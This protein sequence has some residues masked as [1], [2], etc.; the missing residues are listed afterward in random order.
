[1]DLAQEAGLDRSWPHPPRIAL[2]LTMIEY[3][4]NS[5]ISL[6]FSRFDIER[7]R[8]AATIA[9]IILGRGHGFVTRDFCR[10]DGASFK[11]N[12]QPYEIVPKIDAVTLLG[13]NTC[14]MVA[15]GANFVWKRKQFCI[16]FRLF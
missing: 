13:V 1:M 6:T 5:F 9:H 8:K 7:A 15:F 12:G 3:N 14:C 16:S 11:R 10:V 4:A 2:A